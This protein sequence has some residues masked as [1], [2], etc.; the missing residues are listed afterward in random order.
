MPKKKRMSMLFILQD[1]EK[2]VFRG[3]GQNP[4]TTPHNKMV[5]LLGVF[6]PQNTV[7]SHLVK[8]RQDFGVNMRRGLNIL[9]FSTVIL[10][11]K[12]CIILYPK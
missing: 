6:K 7:I 10:G 3:L 1:F 5:I 2:S 11:A 8:S 12:Y 4:G 9:P